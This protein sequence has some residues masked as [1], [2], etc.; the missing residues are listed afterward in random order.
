MKAKKIIETEERMKADKQDVVKGPENEDSER[1]SL[2]DSRRSWVDVM[3]RTRVGGK[4]KRPLCARWRPSDYLLGAFS[5]SMRRDVGW[6]SLELGD[7]RRASMST[8]RSTA[9][10]GIDAPTV[11][12]TLQLAS[13]KYRLP[14]K[15]LIPWTDSLAVTSVHLFYCLYRA[16]PLHRIEPKSGGHS[17]QP[18]SRTSIHRRLWTP[19][20]CSR[21]A[22]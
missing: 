21:K 19:A 20:L 13:A 4:H 2:R 9:N 1:L 7:P 11:L 3:R 15:L 18:E 22:T 6:A 10:Q 17:W 5:L 8:T 14:T 16:H 12:S